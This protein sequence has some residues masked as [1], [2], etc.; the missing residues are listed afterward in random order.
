MDSHESS[1]KT[2]FFLSHQILVFPCVWAAIIHGTGVVAPP[3]ARLPV[4]EMEKRGC[5]K[6]KV[7]TQ[8]PN[9]LPV[10]LPWGGKMESCG[11]YHGCLPECPLRMGE[12]HR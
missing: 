3:Y 2:D 11:F 9:N 10:K 1:T 4:Q 12:D 5:H 6:R 8:S 7:V